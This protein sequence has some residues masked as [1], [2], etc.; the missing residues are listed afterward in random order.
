M[1]WVQ[2]KH[3]NETVLLS[4]KNI[5]KNWWVSKYPQFYAQNE[6]SYDTVILAPKFPDLWLL[7][8]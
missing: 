2:K 5:G 6:L 7:I 8:P 1:L 3:L 4:S